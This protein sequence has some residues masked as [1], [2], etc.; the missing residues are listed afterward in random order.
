MTTTN[1]LVN[2]SKNALKM[3]LPVVAVAVMLGG[4]M[5]QPSDSAGSAE[6]Y[7][8]KGKPDPLMDEPAANR[9]GKLSER[10]KLIQ[11]RQ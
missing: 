7:Q 1:Q 5:P 8:Y 6:E 11:A 10:F 2:T 9:A 4:C 3:F